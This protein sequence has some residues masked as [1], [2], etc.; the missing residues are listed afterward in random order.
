MRGTG[1]QGK[2]VQQEYR[3]DNAVALVW[4]A[5]RIKMRGQSA[6][7]ENRYLKDTYSI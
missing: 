7:A 2:I 6:N 4:S 1:G 3:V 5:N